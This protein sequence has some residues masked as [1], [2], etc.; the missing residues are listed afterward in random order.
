MCLI[1]SAVCIIQPICYIGVYARGS[2][3]ILLG[4]ISDVDAG[5]DVDE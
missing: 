1:Y 4:L 5:D 2:F 3:G